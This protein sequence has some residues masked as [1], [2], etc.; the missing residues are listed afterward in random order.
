MKYTIEQERL[1]KVMMKLFNQILP[2]FVLP[3]KQ[4]IDW[5]FLYYKRFLPLQRLIPHL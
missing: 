4:K 1:M 3:L 5:R 2:D